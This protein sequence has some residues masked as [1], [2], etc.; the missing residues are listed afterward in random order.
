VCSLT[1]HGAAVT[2]VSISADGTRVISG[3]EDT[4]IKIWDADSE[5]SSVVRLRSVW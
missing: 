3:S 1:G 2:S 4:L 5:V